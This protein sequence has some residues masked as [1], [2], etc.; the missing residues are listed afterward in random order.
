MNRIEYEFTE[1]ARVKNI[2]FLGSP[3]RID[4]FS[5]NSTNKRQYS[6]IQTIITSTIP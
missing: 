2:D 1:Q 6:N 5:F 4:M 3:G